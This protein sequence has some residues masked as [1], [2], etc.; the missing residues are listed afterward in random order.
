LNSLSATDAA[1]RRTTEGSCMRTLPVRRLVIGVAAALTAAWLVAPVFASASSTTTTGA[2][3]RL[4]FDVLHFAGASSGAANPNTRLEVGIGIALPHPAAAKAYYLAE[5]TPGNVAYRHFLTPAQFAARFGVAPTTYRRVEGFLRS[6]GLQV[7]VTTSAADWVGATGTVAQIERLFHTAI[8][9]Y[10]WHGQRFLANTSAPTVPAGD[11]I[12]T[13]VGLNTYQKFRTPAAL[14]TKITNVVTTHPVAATVPVPA[15]VRPDANNGP[16]CF[17]GCLYTSPKDFWTLYNMP[18]GD[19]GEGQQLGIFGWGSVTG[20]INDLRLAES[21]HGLPQVPVTV[22]DVGGSSGDTSAADE[23]DLDSQE[24]TGVAPDI[25]DLHFYMA[26]AATD[27]PIENAFA[28]W[29]ADPNGP[30]QMNASFGECETVPGNAVWGNPTIDAEAGPGDNMEAPAEQT[31]LQAAMEGRTL[32]ASAGDTGS[33]CPVIPVNVNGVANEAFPA[34]NYPCSSDYAVCVGG[35]TLYANNSG[36]YRWQEWAWDETGGGDAL[37]QPRAAFQK[38]DTADNLPC[39]AGHNGGFRLSGQPCRG[40][41]DVSAMSGDIATDAVQIYA[42]GSTLDTGGTSL[43]SPLWVGM[44]TRIQAAAPARVVNGVTTYPGLGQADWSIYKAA[45]SSAYDSLFYDVIF[46]ANGY[47][48]AAKGWDYTTGWGSPRLTQLTDWLDHRLTPTNDILPTGGGGGGGGPNA[49]CNAL[50]I[51]SAHTATDIVG[52]QDPQLTLLEG[53]MATSSDGKTLRV[54][55]TVANLSK[56]VP[57]GATGEDWYGTWSYNG[58]EY[59]ADAQLSALPLSQ[60]VFGDGTVTMTGSTRNFNP[61]N[62]NDTGK[63]TVG[64]DG[65]IE[66]DVPLSHVGSPPSGA[67]LIGPAGLTFT[68]LGVPNNPS[69]IYG[70]FLEQVDTGGP[71]LN[72]TVGAPLTGTSG[73]TLPE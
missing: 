20:V 10:A 3:E 2:T 41:P 55:L 12:M 19:L 62:S 57:T 37:F 17:P 21:V 46:G 65:T 43:S 4:A 29:A 36:K 52:N 49:N 33:S 68:E 71:H 61:V 1:I 30:L 11:S 15:G 53:N 70:G 5:N 48:H 73:C 22:T 63:F 72:Y 60:P 50:W 45:E 16:G 35:T 51:S 38:N 66:I 28:D 69:G 64:K 67:T 8:R 6:G 39:L 24:S 40:V 25:L 13:V 23:W 56:T 34:T 9:S 14:H 44:W 59:F 42:A 27:A 54:F 7:N 31:L 47:Y 18:S 58:T 32:F 26:P